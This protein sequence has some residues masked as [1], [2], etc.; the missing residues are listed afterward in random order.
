MYSDPTVNKTT[1]PLLLLLLLLHSSL[2]NYH[3]YNN[4]RH[5]DLF[6]NS[7]VFKLICESMTIHVESYLVTLAALEAIIVLCL[8]EE[9]QGE[10]RRVV[11]W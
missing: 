3:R 4:P 5:V 2:S 8:G 11:W 1:K 10:R 7:N 6:E 9:A